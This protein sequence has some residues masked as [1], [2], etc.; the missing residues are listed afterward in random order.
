[1]W[2]KAFFLSAPKRKSIINHKFISE[3]YG[4][5]FI[6]FH[7]FNW[8]RICLSTS[9]GANA[10]FN[11]ML[12]SSDLQSDFVLT[13]CLSQINFQTEHPYLTCADIWNVLN[14]GKNVWFREME[15]CNDKG[16][17]SGS[18]QR[19]KKDISLWFIFKYT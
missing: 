17:N 2:T 15:L 7:V 16:Q 13:M 19:I 10:W 11:P 12:K 4:N 14:S 9:F 1:M 5:N 18:H 6:C 8:D 3:Q